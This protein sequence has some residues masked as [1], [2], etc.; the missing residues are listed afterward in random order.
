[1]SNLPLWQWYAIPNTALSSV[2]P[3]P[4]PCGA[5]GPQSKIVAWNGATLKRDGS[6]YMLGAAGGHADYC[7]NEVD[8]LALN[9][10]TPQWVQLSPPSPDSMVINESQF[11]LDKKPA[12]TH[13]FYGT[14]FIN[15]RNRMIIPNSPGMLMPGLPSAPS[16]W[17]YAGYQGYSFS[18]NLTTN[19]WDAPEYVA[20]FTG[21]GDYTA[22]LVAKHPTTEDIYYNP[23][24][25]GW[26]KWSQASNSW[27]KLS[28]NEGNGNYAG[29]AIDPKRNRMLIVGNYGGD[30]DPQVRDL[31]GNPISVSFGGMGA[32][33]L[34]LASYPGVVYD[35]VNDKFL[36]FANDVIGIVVYRVDAATLFVDTPSVSGTTPS[37]R[38][39]GIHNSVQYVPE[40][41]GVV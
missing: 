4:Q 28:S 13:T 30:I 3:S 26:W 38:Y 11:F 6:V 22:A 7:G 29:A 21:G 24:G 12:P 33:A 32:A 8:A 23:Y 18:F 37:A 15:A 9:T 34:H 2:A 14:Q 10:A 16:G 41:G 39:N 1:M 19:S 20:M 17:P 36:V 35:E 31:S 40:L 25:A 5:T 27:S